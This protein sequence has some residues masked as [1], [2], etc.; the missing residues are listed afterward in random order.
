[1]AWPCLNTN[2]SPPIVRLGGY[3]EQLYGLSVTPSSA[4]Q[5][6]GIALWHIRNLEVLNGMALPQN[7][8]VG[9]RF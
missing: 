1:M 3:A 6:H 8:I 4:D 5:V 7:S 9:L 2:A